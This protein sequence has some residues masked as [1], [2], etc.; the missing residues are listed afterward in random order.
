MTHSQG[1]AAAFIEHPLFVSRPPDFSASQQSFE[2]GFGSAN[3]SPTR[4]LPGGE[5]QLPLV[6][7]PHLPLAGCCTL[8][9]R[10]DENHLPV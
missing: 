7:P 2:G 8:R 4:A 5:K 3:H 10:G 6:P 9:L 1:R